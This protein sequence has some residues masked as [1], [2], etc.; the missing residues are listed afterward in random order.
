[1]GIMPVLYAIAGFVIGFFIGFVVGLLPGGLGFWMQNQHAQP[2]DRSWPIY[3]IVSISV[4]AGIAAFF[5]F[6]M[7]EQSGGDYEKWL[8]SGFIIGVSPGLGFFIGFFI[9]MFIT[10]FTSQK[11]EKPEDKK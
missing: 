3:I 2:T 5:G 7:I 9:T 4:F 8:N 6:D 11:S 10:F 1:M